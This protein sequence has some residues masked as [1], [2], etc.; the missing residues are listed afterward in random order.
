MP[1][2]PYLPSSEALKLTVILPLQLLGIG[3]RFAH[4][5]LI[6]I[7]IEV[8]ALLSALTIFLRHDRTLSGTPLVHTLPVHAVEEGMSHDGIDASRGVAEATGGLFLE[9]RA[10][11]V[12]G[13]VGD[14][15]G[16]GEL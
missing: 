3:G 11:Q 10:D 7:L 5:L 2:L 9:K 8:P 12:L 13:R 4:G 6:R 1:P 16:R 15:N 14:S